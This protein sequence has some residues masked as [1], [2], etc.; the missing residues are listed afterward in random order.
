MYWQMSYLKIT[1]L[2][3]K[4]LRMGQ[5]NLLTRFLKSEKK[6]S[7]KNLVSWSIGR[8]LSLVTSS[9]EL[10]FVFLNLQIRWISGLL[11]WIW[12]ILSMERQYLLK[13]RNKNL[14]R[15]QI[16]AGCVW[17]QAA[18]TYFL[19]SLLLLSYFSFDKEVTATKNCDC[20]SWCSLMT[21]FVAF[22]KKKVQHRWAFYSNKSRH[23]CIQLSDQLNWMNCGRYTF[24]SLRCDPVCHWSSSLKRDWIG[25]SWYLIQDPDVQVASHTL[26]H[27]CSNGGYARLQSAKC[28]PDASI[29]EKLTHMLESRHRAC[30]KNSTLYIYV[31]DSMSHFKKYFWT[32]LKKVIFHLVLKKH[33]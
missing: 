12:L 25:P 10:N 29:W 23:C 20:S 4:N 5:E 11:S 28:L 22:G 18:L 14:L 17:M 26:C 6:S 7:F 13:V 15:F 32:L 27:H 33:H 9:S 30:S 1:R 21:N 24:D 31:T 2:S 8:Y 16:F 19:F 3:E